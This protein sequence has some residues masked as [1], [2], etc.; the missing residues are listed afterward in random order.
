MNFEYY[1]YIIN[2]DKGIGIL[3]WLI[4]EF[5]LGLTNVALFFF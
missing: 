2:A 4:L 1:T 5:E 3:V